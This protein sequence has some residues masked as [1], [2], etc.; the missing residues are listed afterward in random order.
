M[1]GDEEMKQ[2]MKDMAEIDQLEREE[3]EIL[4]CSY[5]G[6]REDWKFGWGEMDA[7]IE[8]EKDQD[9]DAP[10]CPECGSKMNRILWK[11]GVFYG[12]SEYP[13]CKGKRKI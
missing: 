3:F 1:A 12:C 6:T 11:Y 4:E 8:K 13:K 7:E 2:L 5:P 9:D 10:N